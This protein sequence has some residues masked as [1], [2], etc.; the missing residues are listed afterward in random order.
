MTVP[1]VVMPG[2]WVLGAPKP[3]ALHADMATLR[4]RV[5]W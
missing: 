1:D 3:A 2:G 5:T 4:R